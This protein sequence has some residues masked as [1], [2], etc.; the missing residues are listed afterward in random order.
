M[1]DASNP[2]TKADWKDRIEPL[3]SSSLQDVS[4]RITRSPSVQSWLQRASMEAAEGLVDTPGM[5]GEMMGYMR[6][7]DDLEASLPAL[8]AAVEELTDGCGTIDLNWRPLNP[9]FSRL[10]IDFDRDFTVKVF[11]RLADCSAEA[12]GS[13]LN[14]VA[15]ALPGGDPFPNR[16]NTITGLVARNGSG[17]GVRV[18]EHLGEEGRRYRS[19]TLLPAGRDPMEGLE[20]PVAV[21]QVLQLL[22]DDRSA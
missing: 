15:N 22:C 13:A 2:A 20:P 16:P 1:S 18:K 17:L 3:L 7:M 10:Y 14:T 9:N 12:V 4:D 21:R 11:T 19:V 8:V 6:M 5:Q